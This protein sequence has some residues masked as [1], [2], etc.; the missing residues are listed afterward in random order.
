[1][2]FDEDFDGLDFFSSKFMRKLQSEMNEI[3]EG[4]KSGKIKGNWEL[5][6][7]DEPGVNG[8]IAQGRFGSE[9]SVEPIEPL[10]P[11][12]RRSIPKRLFEVP[13]GALREE[14]EPLVDVFSDK[15]AVK[16]YMELPGE[17]KDNIQVNVTDVGVEIKTKNFRKVVELPEREIVKNSVSTK[18]KNGVL[19][20]TIQ[21]TGESYSEFADQQKMV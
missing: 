3:L 6:E 11:L 14:H 13:E 21:K 5:E 18:Y 7:I 17:E 8:Y 4:I 2:S 20:I 15:S 10:I 19:E 16:I 12:K 9:K 1:M